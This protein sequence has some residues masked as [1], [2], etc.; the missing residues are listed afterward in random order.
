MNMA[1]RF[2]LLEDL[3]EH[4]PQHTTGKAVTYAC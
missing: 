2:D 4:C 1:L 3:D